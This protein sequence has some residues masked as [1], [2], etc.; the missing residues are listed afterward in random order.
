M[1]GFW[2][3]LRATFENLSGR[4]QILVSAA[5]VMVAIAVL[6]VGVVSPLMGLGEG[7]EQDLR[8]A[9]QQLLVVK[10]ML[11]EFDDVDQRLNTVEERIRSGPTG[12]LRTTLETLARQAAVKVESMEPQASPAHDRYRETK[13]EVG[14]GGVSLAQAVSYL[15][16]IE[17]ARQMLSIKSLRIRTRPE[18]P[19]YLD[20][21][22]TVSSFEPL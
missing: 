19:E 1:S 4:E 13:V 18:K 5:G 14:L 8:A 12:N 22:F 21:S 10:R 11:R 17:S 6:I 15:H 16:Q 7:A 9:E 2:K 3:R 20:V